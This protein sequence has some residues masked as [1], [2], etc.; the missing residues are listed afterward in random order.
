MVEHR[1][2]VLPQLG[3]TGV[4]AR[5]VRKA[6]GFKV[7]WGPVRADDIIPF[8]KNGARAEMAMRRVTFTLAER[9]V[10]VPVEFY[11][12]RK[13]LLWTLLAG[14]VLSGIGSP[15]F[16]FSAAWS[17]GLSV[18]TALLL[19]VLAGCLVMPALLP[20]LPGRAFAIKGAVTGIAA[21]AMVAL[22]AAGGALETLALMLF[23]TA[24]S[25]YLAM[26]F[27]GSTPYTSPTGVEK[28]MRA[29]MPLQAAAVL[30]ATVIWVV[31]GFY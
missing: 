22:M 31:A 7:I 9:A 13:M 16:S 30:V 4:C 28:E 27:T 19:G 24:T 5:S 23:A 6:T 26:A 15:L 21:A 2:L 18:A 8:L 11:N 20:W 14:F 29:A 1:Q 12:L 10:L 17:R 25:S 3:A